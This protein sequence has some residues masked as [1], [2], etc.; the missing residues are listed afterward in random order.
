MEIPSV[1]IN[2]YSKF[3]TRDPEWERLSSTKYSCFSHP[4][5]IT[6]KHTHNP[7]VCL[8]LSP[9]YPP[10]PTP[11]FTMWPV[12]TG[13]AHRHVCSL[14][15]LFQ[16]LP[17]LRYAGLFHVSMP[18]VLFCSLDST[19]KWDTHDSWFNTLDFFQENS[20][21]GPKTRP[22]CQWETCTG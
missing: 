7:Y 10:A 9:L 22:G 21:S 11:T 19:Q 13:Y 3:S 18:L 8:P 15:H 17:F 6:L 20:S 1:V 12:C 4:H 5:A 2:F 14:A 16:S